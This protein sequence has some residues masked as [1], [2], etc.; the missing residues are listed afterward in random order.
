MVGLNQAEA[1]QSGLGQEA[2]EG[3][4]M[5]VVAS[6]FQV[7]GGGSIGQIR[8]LGLGELIEAGGTRKIFTNPEKRQ[9][10]DYITGRFG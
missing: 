6:G 3:V 5:D 1:D 7:Q 9:T 8:Q 4:V 2:K 10:E